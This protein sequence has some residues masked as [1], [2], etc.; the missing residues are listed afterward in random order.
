MEKLKAIAAWPMGGILDWYIIR[1]FLKIVALSLLCTTALY[2]IVDFF[3]RIDGIL[4]SGAPVWAAVRYFLYKLPLLMS[5]VF[6]FAVGGTS[7][8]D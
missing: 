7:S 5:R 3:D 6:G 4:K 2:L 8:R 1:G